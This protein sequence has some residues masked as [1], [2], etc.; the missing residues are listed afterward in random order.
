M[1]VKTL[2]LG[3]LTLGDATGYE[4]RKMFEEGPFAYFF[5]AGYG[6]IYPA[7]GKHLEDGL[8]S[9]TEE[10]QS[11]RPDKK[12]YSLTPAGRAH[13]EAALA[14]QPKPDRIRS[15]Y[16]LRLFF[17]DM[18]EPGD[19]K[20]VYD[21]YLAHFDA[22]IA[23]MDSLDPAGVPPGRLFARGFGRRFYE[24]MAAYLRDNREDF[25]RGVVLPKQ[26][27]EAAE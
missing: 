3:V 20:R 5:D 12:V 21:E 10:A 18:M 27:V 8:V 22:M 6:S 19:L 4:I 17:A 26:D 13:F 24:A 9:V 1:D 15:E 23:R 7:L 14:K 16:V 2:C 25:M 11:G